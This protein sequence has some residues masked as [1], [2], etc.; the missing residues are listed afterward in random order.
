MSNWSTLRSAIRAHVVE[1]L[2]FHQEAVVWGAA[3]TTNADPIVMLRVKPLRHEHEWRH[4]VLNESNLLVETPYHVSLWQLSA[5]IETVNSFNDSDFSDFEH[6]ALHWAELLRHGLQ[7]SLRAQLLEEDGLAL[8]DDLAPAPID[9]TYEFD[10]REVC[11]YILEVRLR[12]NF[13]VQVNDTLDTIA[14]VSGTSTL[15]NAGS[16]VTGPFEEPAQ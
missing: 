14:K 3:G 4:G 15:D 13:H 9:A 2:G 1:I 12:S 16:P 10:G 7:T 11:S 6:D 8:V 5:R